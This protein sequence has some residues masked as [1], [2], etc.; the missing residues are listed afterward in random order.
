MGN[1]PGFDKPPAAVFGRGN[2]PLPSVAAALGPRRD[3][4]HCLLQHLAIVISR[5]LIPLIMAPTTKKP[6]AKKIQL[7]DWYDYPQYFDMV[8]RN[9]TAME[10]AFFEEAFKRFATGKVKRVLEP[11]CGSGRLITEMAARGYRCTGLDLSSA[12]L[13]YLQKRLA[14]RDLKADLHEAD[15]T[16]IDLRNR[17][18]NTEQFDAAFCTFNTFRH[19]TTEAA[20]VSHLQSVARHLRP[21]GIYILGFHI[22]P[23]DVAETC[24]ERWT[25]THVQTK[26]TVTL[27]VIDFMRRKRLE[28]IRVSVTAKRPHD[29][30]KLR[31]EFPLRLYT[32][33]Q[34]LQTIASAVDFEIVSVHDFN[35]EIDEPVEVN[36]DSVDTIFVLRKRG[37]Y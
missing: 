12:S 30:I 32:A 21:G 11:G 37:V 20:A 28:Q 18:G 17:L 8:F 13:R 6:P 3:S 24:I 19:L 31:T 15:F 23:L 25:A 16:N 22:I 33:K 14:R 2:S 26:V 1:A 10:V 5:T 35:Y 27:R 9:E 34:S 36:E 4:L 29:T 7:A